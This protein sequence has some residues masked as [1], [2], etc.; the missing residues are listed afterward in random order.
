[1]YICICGR[2]K[3]QDKITSIHYTLKNIHDI[4]NG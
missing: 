2:A 3:G 1:M 4:Q